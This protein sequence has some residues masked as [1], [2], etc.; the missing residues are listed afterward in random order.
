MFRTTNH[1]PSNV[2]MVDHT[3]LH[4]HVVSCST[5]QALVKTHVRV[6][7]TC[8]VRQLY[9]PL[10]TEPHKSSDHGLPKVIS[11]LF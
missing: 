8:Y 1:C 6:G 10:V 11:Q 2:F 9:L 7:V 5:V 3:I 4:V